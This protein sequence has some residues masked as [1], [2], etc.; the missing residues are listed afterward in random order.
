MITLFHRATTDA[1]DGPCDMADASV[2]TLGGLPG[3]FIGAAWG[4]HEAEA[5]LHCQTCEP[6]EV[7]AVLQ[8]WGLKR[9]E[10]PALGGQG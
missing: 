2:L 3:G 7:D 10:F 4:E 8:S 1:C 6:E 9:P 5:A